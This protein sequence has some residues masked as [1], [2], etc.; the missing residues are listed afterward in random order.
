MR[1]D[2]AMPKSRPLF[3]KTFG[4]RLIVWLPL[5]LN[6][7]PGTETRRESAAKW[8]TPFSMMAQIQVT[9]EVLLS[10]DAIVPG[11]VTIVKRC[12]VA[13]RALRYRGKMSERTRPPD[14][15]SLWPR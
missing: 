15:Q 12:R 5:T 1:A 14:T 3:W 13:S 6:G 11:E 10:V 7:E 4:S 2:P 9:A 8:G